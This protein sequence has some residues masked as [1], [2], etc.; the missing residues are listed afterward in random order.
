MIIITIIIK[1]DNHNNTSTRVAAVLVLV[2]PLA[3]FNWPTF[4]CMYDPPWNSK[5]YINNDRFWIKNLGTKNIFEFGSLDHE[6]FTK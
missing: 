6:I 3:G 5:N 4:F 2:L 1:N